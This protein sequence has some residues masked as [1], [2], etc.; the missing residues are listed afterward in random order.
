[1]AKLNYPYAAT[2]GGT[3]ATGTPTGAI[4]FKL[5]LFYLFIL[6]LASVHSLRIQR[7]KSVI[8]KN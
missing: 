4:M 3:A 2:G 7:P 5:F 8:I 1:M 6:F